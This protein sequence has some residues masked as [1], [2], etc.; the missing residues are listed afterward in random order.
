MKRGTAWDEE[1][2]QAS[3]GYETKAITMV[4]EKKLQAPP[5]Q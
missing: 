5:T 4:E 2:G 3:T 1:Q